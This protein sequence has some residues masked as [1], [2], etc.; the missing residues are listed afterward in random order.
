MGRCSE[1]VFELPASSEAEEFFRQN[2]AHLS[3]QDHQLLAKIHEGS[4]FRELERVIKVAEE[5]V[6]LKTRCAD[7]PR[8]AVPLPNV[9]DYGKSAVVRGRML[10]IARALLNR[11]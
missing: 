10:R 6:V 11:R 5:Q 8:P 1:I 9:R 4:S 3:D 7:T 2:A